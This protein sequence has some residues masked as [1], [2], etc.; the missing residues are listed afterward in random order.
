MF[1]WE[2]MDRPSVTELLKHPWFSRLDQAA[3]FQS[4]LPN[5]ENQRIF[6]VE[7]TVVAPPLAEYPEKIRRARQTHF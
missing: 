5:Y 6:N 7:Y 1:R 4:G 2:P 3:W